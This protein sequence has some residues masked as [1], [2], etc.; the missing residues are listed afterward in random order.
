[1]FHLLERVL[2]ALQEP[3]GPVVTF[4]KLWNTWHYIPRYGISAKIATRAQSRTESMLQGVLPFWLKYYD[5][6]FLC[7]YCHFR[8][9]GEDSTVISR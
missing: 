8:T 9:L 1:M 7:L 4:G 2:Q 6:T 3:W 5:W